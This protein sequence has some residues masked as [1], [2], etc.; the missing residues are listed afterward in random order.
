M[1]KSIQNVTLEK[2]ENVR[3][4]AVFSARNV[5]HIVCS[6]SFIAVRGLLKETRYATIELCRCNEQAI[7]GQMPQMKL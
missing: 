4:Q 1:E 6:V 7:Q 5:T 2:T 3:D